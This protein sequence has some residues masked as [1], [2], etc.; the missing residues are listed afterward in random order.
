[1]KVIDVTQSLPVR[2]APL[3]LP[4]KDALAVTVVV[5]TLQGSNRSTHL[6]RFPIS[7][8]GIQ[9]SSSPHCTSTFL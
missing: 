7:N 3:C 4:R 9:L 2:R 8:F 6:V 1:M 5:D